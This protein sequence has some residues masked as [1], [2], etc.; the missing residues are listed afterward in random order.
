MLNNINNRVLK[1]IKGADVYVVRVNAKGELG[2]S[3]PCA[4]CVKWMHRLGVKR[5]F[6]STGPSPPPTLPL[7]SPPFPFPAPLLPPPSPFVSWD[8]TNWGKKKVADLVERLRERKGEEKGEGAYVTH[9]QKLL[10]KG[11][12]AFKR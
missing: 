1:A 3:H 9:S 7:P 11:R 8:G 2:N 5:V 4:E 10:K 6:F 12:N